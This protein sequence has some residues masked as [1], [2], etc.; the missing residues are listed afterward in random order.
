MRLASVQVIPYALPFAEPYVTARGTLRRREMVLLKLRDEEGRYGLGEAVPLAL[1]GGATLAQVA[2]ELD[3]LDRGNVL[4]AAV[5]RG[6]VG[7]A[8]RLPP[9]LELSAPARC[10]AL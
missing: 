10:A 6:N 9:E 3:G 1:R 4:A 7:E 2:E 8:A 5:E